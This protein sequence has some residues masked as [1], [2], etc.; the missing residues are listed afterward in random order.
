MCMCVQACVCVCVCARMHARIYVCV[1]VCMRAATSFTRN[2]GDGLFDYTNTVE[3]LIRKH[4][5]NEQKPASYVQLRLSVWPAEC[6]CFTYWYQEIF[7][8]FVSGESSECSTMS[9]ILYGR[10]IGS[11][12]KQ[13]KNWRL[14][15]QYFIWL[16]NNNIEGR[17]TAPK[18]TYRFGWSN[19]YISRFVNTTRVIYF[20]Y[21]LLSL[22]IKYNFDASGKKMRSKRFEW[23]YGR[24]VSWCLSPVNH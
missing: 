6:V 19:I 15:S 11:K 1:N 3:L 17:K 22:L 5:S 2:I 24:L 7:P 13:K 12:K 21:V 18:R 9:G 23:R 14:V 8:K 16:Y 20:K 10:S 4:C